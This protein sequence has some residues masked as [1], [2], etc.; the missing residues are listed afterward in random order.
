MP[1]TG[2]RRG[3]R[4]PRASSARAP[5]TSA[6]SRSGLLEGPETVGSV[7]CLHAF[8]TWPVDAAGR[9]RQHQD[10]DGGHGRE[11]ADQHAAGACPRGV[12]RRPVG[13]EEADGQAGDGQRDQQQQQQ[14]AEAP[15]RRRRA[16][17]SSRGP[18][19]ALP[20][21]T[22]T[23][24][25]GTVATSTPPS[26]DQRRAA[27]AARSRATARA[28]ARR[29]GARRARRPASGRRTSRPSAG[30][31]EHVEPRRG[32]SGAQ[33]ARATA[34]CP[35]R[36]RVRRCSSTRTAAA[37]GRTSRRARAPPGR[38]WSAATSRRSRRRP[39]ATPTSSAPQLPRREPAER[40]PPANTARYANVR[41]VSS[42]ESRRHQ[43]PCDRE[44]GE[45]GQHREGG[46]RPAAAQTRRRPLRARQDTARAR[47]APRRRA[48]TRS[49]STSCAR[50]A[51]RRA[52]RTR[53]ARSPARRRRRARVPA[54]PARSGRPWPAAPRAG[55]AAARRSSYA[56]G[57]ARPRPADQGRPAAQAARPRAAARATAIMRRRA[58]R[59]GRRWRPAA[60]RR[61]TRAS[62][63]LHRAVAASA[64]S[65]E[66]GPGPAG[67]SGARSASASERSGCAPVLRARRVAGA[68]AGRPSTACR[69]RCRRRR[70]RAA[71]VA[72]VRS[73]S[74]PRSRAKHV[75][76]VGVLVDLGR[77]LVARVAQLRERCSCPG[78]RRRPGSPGGSGSGPPRE[79]R[80]GR[81]AVP[82]AGP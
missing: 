23:A 25:S 17:P 41:F 81:G 64:A 13:G 46:E 44:R 67:C 10:G 75:A 43:R 15:G 1:S 37:G 72:V 50:A 5:T 51:S 80:R 39:I 3:P 66:R 12:A 79:P 70:C 16:V 74:S 61:A 35:A 76:A 28:R 55:C 22:P 60:R 45:H 42:H 47:T 33:P 40:E 2:A 52:R 14:R 7:A 26:I 65:L 78:A 63:D 38:P 68:A 73:T 82:R 6:V 48:S 77:Q 58:G 54:P 4:S 11:R 69:R 24:T 21:R 34:G 36:R 31:G 8:E 18:R 57:R 19:P 62:V 56:C 29:P 20:A 71:A 59:C 53:T 49:R 32:P 27:A 9:V 30:P